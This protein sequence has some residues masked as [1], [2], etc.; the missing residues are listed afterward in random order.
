[1]KRI[2][3]KKK[4]VL[5]WENVPEPKIQGEN[6]AIVKPIA[7]SRCD[8]DLPIVNGYT[9]FRPG[10][11]IGHEFVGTIEETS[12]EIADE[13][14]KGTK[15]IIPFQISCGL[16]PDCTGGRSKACTSIPYASHYGMGPSAKEF[17][18]AL[19]ER[20]WIPFAKQMI[21]PMPSNMDAIALASISDNIVEAWK[22]VGQWLE[23]KPN[24]PVMI[25][26]G[27]ASSIGLYSASLAVGMGASEVLYLDNDQERLKIA[28]NLGASAVSYST[29]P[30]VWEKKFPLIADCH[31]LKEGMDFSLKSLSTEGIYGSASIFWTNKLEI[32][33]LDL[34][35]TGATLKIGRVDSREHIPQILNKIV[36]KKIEPEK[37]V[38]KTCSFDDAVEAWLEPAIKLVVK[39]DS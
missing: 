37:I 23:K 39:M 28:E 36:E 34:Y 29:L 31:G 11:P 1:M 9:L 13:Y 4:H 38:T 19:S 6:Q 35:N 30:K 5:E 21:I 14:P 32:P 7:V 16:C 33:Y 2:V 10:I 8:L 26:G 3:F 12:P 17:G 25:L 27:L 20:I 18:G 24:S 15:V 22:L